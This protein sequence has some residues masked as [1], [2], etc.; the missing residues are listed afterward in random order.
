MAQGSNIAVNDAVPSFDI[1]SG[2]GILIAVK[3][4]LAELGVLLN[5]KRMIRAYFK[6]FHVAQTPY[7]LLQRR[8]FAV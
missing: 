1:L 6:F 4:R 3:Q 5:A 7:E 8:E 2:C